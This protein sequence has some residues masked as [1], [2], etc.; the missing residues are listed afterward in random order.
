MPG[1]IEADNAFL[2]RRAEG[3]SGSV[4]LHPPEHFFRNPR[5][6]F[7]RSV[8]GRLIQNPAFTIGNRYAVAIVKA[9]AFQHA[10]AFIEI[11]TGN[12]DGGKISGIV[13]DRLG[14]VNR[15]K[16]AGGLRGEISGREFDGVD[17]IPDALCAEGAG[18]TRVERR[19]GGDYRPIRR[20]RRQ[21]GIGGV[22]CAQ[23][24][25]KP[26]TTVRIQP[27][28]FGQQGQTVE[29]LPDPGRDLFLIGRQDLNDEKG[30]FLRFLHFM[31]P[32]IDTGCNDDRGGRDEYDHQ[33]ERELPAYGP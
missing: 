25:K 22:A 15:R 30:G 12:D 14:I 4:R 7:E 29:H 11:E 9:H 26:L 3:A 1:G 27:P 21:D 13:G 5:S 33:Q 24:P 17:G 10:N 31:A 32:L 16:S 23:F 6:G 19:G 2:V 28:H 18:T 20:C 8:S